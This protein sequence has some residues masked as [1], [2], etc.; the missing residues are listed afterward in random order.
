MIEETIIEWVKDEQKRGE[1]VSI[2]DKGEIPNLSSVC[3]DG[4]FNLQKLVDRL[5]AI[6]KE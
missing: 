3:L 1:W 2:N 5:K 4:D 6:T